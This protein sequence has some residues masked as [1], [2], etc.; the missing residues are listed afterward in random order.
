MSDYVGKFL[1][2]HDQIQDCISSSG[3][4][5]ETLKD[6]FVKDNSEKKSEQQKAQLEILGYLDKFDDKNNKVHDNEMTR[7]TRI[8]N[9]LN[10]GYREN[11]DLLRNKAGLIKI[12]END[13]E[14]DLK[15]R[16]EKQS[17]YLQ[18]ILDTFKEVFFQL[19]SFR[20]EH[21]FIDNK[22]KNNFCYP[23]NFT[24]NNMFCMEDYIAMRQDLLGMVNTFCD[25]ALKID[26]GH[27]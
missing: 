8:K 27:R 26:M 9:K 22:D 10:S 16:L 1:D 7:C 6:L 25:R 14:L 24:S 23:I 20:M 11:F 21:G 17:L 12:S 5:L 13:T 19:T 4:I 2:K 15:V 3:E 18:G